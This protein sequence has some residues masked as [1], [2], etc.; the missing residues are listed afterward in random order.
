[1][2]PK[3][4]SL[5]ALHT[6]CAT[7][8]YSILPALLIA[9]AA[10]EQSMPG[11]SSSKTPVIL[12]FFALDRKGEPI[13]EVRRDDLT[14][15]DTKQ[16]SLSIVSV[17]KGSTLPLRLGLVIDDSNSE[18]VSHLFRPAVK[19]ASTLLSQVLSGPNDRVAII[20]VSNKPEAT[21]LM[22]RDEFLK[23]K[24]EVTLGGGTA[25]YDGVA[26]ASD[27]LTKMD[28]T[29]LTRRVLILLTDGDDNLSR[30]SRDE[31]LA[32]ALKS[33][34]IIFAVST[35]DDS[36]PVLP[37][38]TERNNNALKVLS[39]KTGGRAFLNLDR[40][41]IDETFA[42]I[43]RQIAG[44]YAIT[45]SQADDGEKG[46]HPIKLN[47]SSASKVKMRAPLGYYSE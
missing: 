32:G 3:S 7:C 14:V 36:V 10:V 42:E 43:Q 24:I 18:S 9:H 22:S 11:D 21:S 16:R 2:N 37:S 13:S 38:Y 33:G 31:A 30:H 25:L 41:Q 44:M 6:I 28:T 45:F 23:H 1:M 46:F 35:A 20:K 17:E 40:R 34:V 27:Q 39:E 4:R 26:L 19:A 5:V 8:L 12:S 47:W 29:R 15:L